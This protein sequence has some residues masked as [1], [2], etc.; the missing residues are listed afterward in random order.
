MNE[1]ELWRKLK[2]G[3]KD[4]LESIYRTHIQNLLEYGYRFTSDQS[5]VEDC[6][7]DLFI[8]LWINRDGLSQTNSIRPYLLVSL[9]RKIIRKVQKTKK[10]MSEQT[11]DEVD[12]EVELA[13]D[14]VLMEQET[15]E[16][17]RTKLK[18]AFSKLSKRQKE[19]LYL[20]FYQNLDYQAICNTMNISYQSA[21]NL[22]FKGIQ[23]LK[24]QVLI[25]L[26][27]WLLWCG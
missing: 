6:L 21:R 4:A 5:L 17:Q 18:N 2:A 7:H 13:I 22:V 27:I 10:Q 20:K 16:E 14:E 25:T 12:F 23:S 11:A 19:A 9:R 1:A 26:L 15:S 3:D 8:E 24:E